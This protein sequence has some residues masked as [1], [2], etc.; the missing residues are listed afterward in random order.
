MSKS[1][2]NTYT[3]SQLK[4]KGIFP[5]AYKLFCFT[6]HYRNQLNFTF[7]G[8]YGAQKA[9][10][11]L[12]ESYEKHLSN[13]SKIDT[14]TMESYR[15]KFTDAINDDM[16]M[17]QAMSVVWEVARNES[18]SIDY[19]KLLEEFDEV[20]GLDLKNAPK[21]LSEFKEYREN[22]IPEEIIELAEKRKEARE[23]KDWEKSDELRE[24]ILQKGYNIKDSKEGYSLEKINK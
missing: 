7:D 16:N 10:E 19:A 8:A 17:P 2:G 1:L 5:L 14:E 13:N 4:E 9:L 23:N 18:K 6:A 12:Y 11:R 22:Q 3:I 15:K 20:L 24:N 21:Y